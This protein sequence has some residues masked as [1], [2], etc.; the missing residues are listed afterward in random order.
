MYIRF[1]P[2]ATQI[3]RNGAQGRAR[4]NPGLF[5]LARLLLHIGEFATS[6]ELGRVADRASM[7]CPP[8]VRKSPESGVCASPSL[9]KQANTDK[10]RCIPSGSAFRVETPFFFYLLYLSIYYLY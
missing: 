10:K 3:D 7:P 1:S 2:P 5:A 4:Q 6:V 9:G 8:N